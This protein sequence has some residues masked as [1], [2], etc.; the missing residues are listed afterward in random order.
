MR[1]AGRRSSSSA[2][3]LQSATCPP[4]RRKA[5][6]RQKWSVS[7]WIVVVRPPRERPRAWLCSPFSSCRAAVRFHGG[8][9]DQPLRRRAASLCKRLEQ[10]DPDP[11]GQPNARS[12]C[13]ASSSA[14]RPR[15]VRPSS[16]R[17]TSAHGHFSTWTMPLITHRSSTR[18]LP[19]VSFGRCGAIFA[20]GSSVSQ[21]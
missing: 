3:A 6:G 15:A 2:P 8:G 14:R 12:G 17:R 16:D 5:R 11:L 4:V 13:R 10:R 7:A 20:N 21:N 9:I 18:S 19:R 1:Q